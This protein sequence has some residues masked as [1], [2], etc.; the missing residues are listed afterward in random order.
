MK[1]LIIK[2]KW[3][4]KILRGE[5]VWEI[6]GSGCSYTGEIALIESGSGA[7]RG[8][9][10]VS[11]VIGPMTIEDLLRFTPRHQVDEA[12]LLEWGGYKNNYC[13]ALT[14]VRKL[15]IPVSYRHPQGAVIWVSSSNIPLKKINEAKKKRVKPKFIDIE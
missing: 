3:L 1:G 7:V 9:A 12:T 10:R 8:L 4:D 6:R 15:E 2:K 5:K 14:D 13:W 11:S